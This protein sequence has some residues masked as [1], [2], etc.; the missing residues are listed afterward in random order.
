LWKIFSEGN[1]ILL[2]RTIRIT[3]DIILNVKGQLRETI[4]PQTPPKRSPLSGV[5]EC[6]VKKQIKFN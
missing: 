2:C 3:P 4:A 5:S 1:L 6:G